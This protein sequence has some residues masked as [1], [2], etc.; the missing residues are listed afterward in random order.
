MDLRQKELSDWQ[1][2]NFPVDKLLELDKGELV[3]IILIQQ[4]ALGMNEEAGEVAHHIL[5]GIQRIRGGTGGIDWKEVIDGVGDTDIFGLQLLS[6]GGID[7]EEALPPVT[8]H[9]LSRNWIENP[10]DPDKAVQK[11]FNDSLCVQKKCIFCD[12]TGKAG[13]KNCLACDGTGKL[14]LT[15]D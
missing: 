8:D 6:L 4:M 5:K 13:F 3:K 7:A 14:V 1:K 12:G 11:N 15:Y 9:V 10:E 2:K